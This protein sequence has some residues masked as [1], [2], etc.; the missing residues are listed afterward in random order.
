MHNVLD[1]RDLST[2][3]V[4]LG[5]RENIYRLSHFNIPILRRLGGRRAGCT[6]NGHECI[7]FI[8]E[9]C[10]AL[11]WCIGS[12]TTANTCNFPSPST[13]YG[14]NPLAVAKEWS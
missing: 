13:T 2:C 1:N 3:K 4:P 12:A 9:L 10:S 14:T 11:R 5:I 8:V 7:Y 6:V